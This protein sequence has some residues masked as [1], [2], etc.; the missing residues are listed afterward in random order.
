MKIEITQPGVFGADG[1]E[2]AVGTEIEVKGDAVPA[3]L[4]GKGRVIGEKPKGAT[5][6]VNPKDDDPEKA[7]L[8]KQAEELGID[9]DKRWGVEKIKAAIDAKLAE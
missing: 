9:V 2:I 3:W 1:K 8:I 4:V 5:M 7:E 6:V